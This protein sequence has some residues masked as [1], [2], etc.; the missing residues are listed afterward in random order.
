[1]NSS[2]G[3]VAV[4][5]HVAQAVALHRCAD[6][7]DQQ[8]REHQ[9]R[10]EADPAAELEAEERAQHVEAGMGEVEHAHHAEDEVSPL[11]IR[12]SSMPNST[13]F[14]VEMTMSSST[15]SLRGA[16]RRRIRQEQTAPARAIRGGA[17]A[18]L[19]RPHPSC[20]SWAAWSAAVSILATSCQPQPVFSSSNGS[21]VGPL[22]E[23]GDVHRLEE[24][25]V[26]LAHDALAAVEH[27]ELHVLERGRRPSP[28]RATWPFDGRDR[29]CAS[30]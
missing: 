9:R 29:A 17:N 6:H 11:A 15:S 8:R 28:D 26:V 12:N 3:D 21:F 14:S 10:P 19:V 7:A 13:P 5:V 1:M 25:V 30:G 2:S 18:V 16:D 22:A 24:L 4:L 27:L 20:R 23:R